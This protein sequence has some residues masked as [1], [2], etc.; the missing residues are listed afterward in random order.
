MK[1]LALSISAIA[2]ALVITVACSKDQKV[3]K[4]LEGD[5]KV[6]A[7]T[8]NGAA[9]PAEE[10]ANTTYSFEKCKVKKGD[11]AGTMSYNDPTKG[12]VSFPFTYSISEK[13]TIFKMTL[14]IT[15]LG[16]ETTSS[17]IVESSKTKFVFSNKDAD[18]DVTVTTLEKK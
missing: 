17:D 11:C 1:K 3:V 14:T 6:T 15:G 4:Q 8:Y 7:V 16:S 13:G 18:G 9:A 12:T 2:I 10:Y 5:W